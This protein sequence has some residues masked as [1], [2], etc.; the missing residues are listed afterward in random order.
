MSGA[1]AE[2]PFYI[3]YEEPEGAFYDPEAT[4]PIR[5]AEPAN[6][7]NEI[8]PDLRNRPD[9]LMS[10]TGAKKWIKLFREPK[11]GALDIEAT[12]AALGIPVSFDYDG[13]GLGGIEGLKGDAPVWIRLNPHLKGCEDGEDKLTIGHEMGHAFLKLVL[14]Y[15]G[16]G[17]SYREEQFCEQFGAEVVVPSERLES[18]RDITKEKILELASAYQTSI[19][20]VVHQLMV[21]GKLPPK[22]MIDSRIGE[23]PNLE[24]SRK[25]T[26][27]TCCLDCDF[28]EGSICGSP[29]YK[30]P[31]FDFTD[32]PISGSLHG[33]VTQRTIRPGEAGFQELNAHYAA[34]EANSGFLI[35]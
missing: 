28:N 9:T 17:Y 22:V 16:E 21:A 30:I 24:Y 18:I 5:I 31:V 35:I 23:C 34:G 29:D 13:K 20:I 1:Y 15:S 33:C 19:R 14:G 25:V 12:A 6:W 27:H 4:D 32:H 8:H 2:D 7:I 26:R 3:A 10:L 11:E